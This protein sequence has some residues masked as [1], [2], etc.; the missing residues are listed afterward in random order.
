[1]KLYKLDVHT[2][3]IYSPTT[4]VDII[5]PVAFLLYV[6]AK[7]KINEKFNKFLCSPHSR[8]IPI[9]FYIHHR[10]ISHLQYERSFLS[11]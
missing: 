7:G 6:L 2:N 1:M 5:L 8:I 9:K 10:H 11:F 3:T 4:H